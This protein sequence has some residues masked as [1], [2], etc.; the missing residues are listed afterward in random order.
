MS[1]EFVIS[2][3][4]SVQVPNFTATG[5]SAIRITQLEENPFDDGSAK[6]LRKSIS[7]SFSDIPQ[8]TF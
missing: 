6:V 3:I 5:E 8:E 7:V 2:S 4:D 1:E